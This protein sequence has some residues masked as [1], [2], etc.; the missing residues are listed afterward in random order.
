[1]EKKSYLSNN[2]EKKSYLSNKK[3]R[4]FLLILI[5]I[6]LFLI[7]LLKPSVVSFEGL[8]WFLSIFSALCLGW[9]LGAVIVEIRLVDLVDKKENE[10]LSQRLATE[11]LKEEAALTEKEKKKSYKKRSKTKVKKVK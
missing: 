7:G 10:C 2:M 8:Y 6:V 4:R 1:M 5:L 3:E 9:L 11:E